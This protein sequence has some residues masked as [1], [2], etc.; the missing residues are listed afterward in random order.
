MSEAAVDL[1]R[2]KILLVDDQPA[3]LKVLRLA[4]EPVGY[5]ILAAGDGQ[6]A[7][8]IAQRARPDLILLDVTMPGMDG[9]ET[10]RRLKG[11]GATAAI[12]VLF[13]TARTETEDVVEGFG[14]GGADYIA[15]PFRNEEVM[16]RVQTH[17]ERTFLERALV[18]SND[19]LG[20]KNE[21]LQR[22][23]DQ[24]RI[25]TGQKQQLTEQLSMISQREAERWGIPGF[26]GKSTLL[27]KVLREIQLLQNSSSTS[28]L[29]TG[30]SGTGKEL[31][32]RALHFGSER[33]DGPFVPVNCSAVPQE[34]AES[35]FFGH[36]KGAFTGADTERKGHF[37][38]AHGGTLFL[39]E[40]GDMPLDLQA[41]LLR[42]LE[43]GVVAPLGGNEGRPVDVRVVS[44]TNAD[45]QAGVAAGTFRQDLYFR[46][47]SF[48]V[49]VPPLRQRPEDIPLLVEHF[50][51]LLAAEMGQEP[52]A[53]TGAALERL[54]AYAF[55]GNIRELKNIVERAL[56]ESG[57]RAIGPEH[58]HLFYA[59]D[60][61]TAQL[62]VVPSPAPSEPLPLNLVEAEKVLMRRALE[63][64]D[65]NIAA[66][67]RLL[68][69]NRPRVYRF[70]R[71]QEESP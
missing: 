48:P 3:N 53:P 32:A 68:G 18:A 39:D 46:L 19:E 28:V 71:E 31:V 47:A 29:I 44:A 58:V 41:K 25:L 15:K 62:E 36:A 12:P 11:D 38:L 23:I 54:R 26:V 10:C 6:R 1:K 40:V 5:H 45:L 67:A 70:L 51:E 30:E 8:D 34:L 64:T 17:L 13:I 33:A 55:P 50:L 22:E 42:V 59:P 9:F 56:L 69:T 35:Q 21:E 57:G 20:E 60:T 16:A 37:E 27:Q 61:G 49:Q 14:V 52:V 2:A 43:D 7:L 4:L 24:R 65:N 66:A 63:Q